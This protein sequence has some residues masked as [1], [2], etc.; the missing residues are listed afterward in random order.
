ML[1]AVKPQD[2]EVYQIFINIPSKQKT[3]TL[4]VSALDSIGSIKNKIYTLEGIRKI[5]QQLKFGLTYL[6]PDYTLR[7]YNIQKE[8]TLTLTPSG[9]GGGKRA[10][11]KEDDKANQQEVMTVL[12]AKARSKLE[13]LDDKDIY[14]PNMKRTIMRIL[15]SQSNDEL[16]KY[17]NSAT[18]KEV[19]ELSDALNGLSSVHSSKVAQMVAPIILPEYQKMLK[20]LELLDGLRHAANYAVEL[21]YAREFFYKGNFNTNGFK[22][23]VKTRPCRTLIACCFHVH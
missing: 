4:S 13:V 17:I 8:D 2:E 18:L 10:R 20:S 5:S 23:L 16:Q 12:I 7:Y 3:L 15:E 1:M 14:I 19:K 22:L 21:Q 6:L 11:N 9:A